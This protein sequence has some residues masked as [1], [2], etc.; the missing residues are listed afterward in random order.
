MPPFAPA[1]ACWACLRP[2]VVIPYMDAYI[3]KKARTDHV[4]G[5][6]NVPPRQGTL[7][8]HANKVAPWKTW[9][10]VVSRTELIA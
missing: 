9:W 1:P 6:Q 8:R 5:L 10:T 7:Q 2:R 4:L 3:E